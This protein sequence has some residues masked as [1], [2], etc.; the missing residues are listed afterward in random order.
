MRCFA[1]L[2]ALLWS[3]AA[4]ADMGLMLLGAQS[5]P[6]FPLDG[7]TTPTGCYST[8]RLRAAYVTNKAM[9]V[10]RASDSATMDIGFL[11]DGR[12]DTATLTT[13]LA[14]TTGKDV[15]FYDQCGAFDLTQATD[16][17]RP[18]VVLTALGTYAAMQYTAGTIA[19]A[20]AG[21]VT[22]ATGLA[23]FSAV[24]NRT[25]G[26]GACRLIS[27]NGSAGNSLRTAA[28][29]N[30]WSIAGGSG[31]TVAKAATDATWHAASGVVNGAA[32]FVNVDGVDSSLGTATG[33]TT[34]AAP[35]IVGLASTTCQVLEAAFWDNYSL[36]AIER[37]YLNNNQH[38]FW[39]F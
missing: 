21:N 20:A 29:G 19:L 14:A 18:P 10:V 9:N 24:A 4:Q 22:P 13:F 16:A 28:A 39:R 23:S 35:T 25:V 36:T 31:G 11:A 1:F 2:A 5:P 26:T 32:S 27:E 15:T 6:H 30:Q 33:S 3:V 38:A 8:R 34:A 7:L 17:N 37:T 12:P